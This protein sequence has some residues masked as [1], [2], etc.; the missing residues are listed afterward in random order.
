MHKTLPQTKLPGMKRYEKMKY[1]VA[2][3]EIDIFQ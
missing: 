1:G 3:T 2:W